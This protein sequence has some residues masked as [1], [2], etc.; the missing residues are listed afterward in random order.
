MASE[1]HTKVTTV[2]ALVQCN[3]RIVSFFIFF[4]TAIRDLQWTNANSINQK[5]LK[6]V[7]TFE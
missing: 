1:I 6:S 4:Y 2:F 3:S 7:I 5:L